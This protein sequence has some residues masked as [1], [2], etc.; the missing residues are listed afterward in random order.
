MMERRLMTDAERA[1]IA[2]IELRKKAEF[3][4]AGR[5]LFGTGFTARPPMPGK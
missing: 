3:D 2:E 1:E 4:A 5:N